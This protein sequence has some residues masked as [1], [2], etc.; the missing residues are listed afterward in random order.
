MFTW[1][2][3]NLKYILPIACV[4][5]FLL[6]PESLYAQGFLRYLHPKTWI[7][8]L[9]KLVLQLGGLILGFAGIV[10]EMTIQYTIVKMKDF[11]NGI[12]S[13]DLAWRTIRDVANIL[14]IFVLLLI[15]INIIL[16]SWGSGPY[17]KSL[18]PKVIIAAL[19]INF[20]LFFTKVV[21]DVSNIITFEFYETA[22][23]VR[24]S[25]T[26]DLPGGVTIDT[27]LTSSF[28]QGLG[29]SKIA[30][31]KAAATFAQSSYPV[32]SL[33]M[34]IIT[35]LVAAFVFLV[36]AALLIVRFVLFIFLMITSP[37][38]FLGELLPQLR[39]HSKKWWETLSAQAA[40]AP[41]F[42]V[43]ILIVVLIINDDQFGALV[44]AP[45]GTF[46]QNVNTALIQMVAILFQYAIVIGMIV[47]ALVAAKQTSNKA[48][49]G[50]VKW[51]SK[52][53]G[54][55]VFG[56]TAALGRN[57]L[58][59]LGEKIAQ[60]GTLGTAV[61]K[62]GFR[63]SLA[64]GLILAGDK[65]R[66]WTYDARAFKDVSGGD[67]SAGD[68]GIKGG[69][70]GAREAR[71][72]L[73]QER[74]G[75]YATAAG[76]GGL[77]EELQKA[78][79][80]GDQKKAAEI[81]EQIAKL[82]GTRT[83]SQEALEKETKKLTAAQREEAQTAIRVI[84]AQE[85]YI[86]GLQRDFRLEQDPKKKAELGAKIQATVSELNT[87]KGTV[88][89]YNAYMDAHKRAESVA[90]GA[91]GAVTRAKGKYADT[92]AS[93]GAFISTRNAG[94]AL[95]A[96]MKKDSGDAAK[97]VIKAMKAA[98]Q[99]QVRQAGG[100]QAGGGAGGRVRRGAGQPP[101]GQPAGGGGGPQNPAP[102]QPPRQAGGAILNPQ[103]QPVNAQGTTVPPNNPPNIITP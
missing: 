74:A 68:V 2:K 54:K 7:E 37:I 77:E 30:T 79:A 64:K 103:G 32:F 6:L 83:S 21:I 56:G 66:S 61:E 8:E 47:A 10:L 3:K 15:S 24:S 38:A 95:R 60:S 87:Y 76:I 33:T 43:L 80:A 53:A 11:V 13:I 52:W 57:T 93:G 71:Q 46:G 89:Q 82:K 97:E 31:D 4:A 49:E 85:A 18:I 63:G 17:N 81:K 94:D 102:P 42:F 45:P 39:T 100:G 25:G 9:L 16:G 44:T 20:S 86:E 48:G 62:G 65:G 96:E 69:L 55:A 91:S 99:A 59:R 98:A 67:F 12:P 50:F 40:F 75:K 51:G 1:L 28:M 34:G 41:I 73:I 101:Q 84:D 36:I 14:F 5:L 88:A 78:E 26:I 27:G 72:K 23:S 29:V 35:T 19:L 70:V 90:K 92:L 22:K 58:G